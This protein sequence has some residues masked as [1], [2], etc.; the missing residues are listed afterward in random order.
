MIDLRGVIS[1]SGKRDTLMGL[2]VLKILD[3]IVK[4]CFPKLVRKIILITRTTFTFTF[5][6]TFTYILLSKTVSLPS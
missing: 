6:P 5:K 2:N 1:V 3:M 4:F